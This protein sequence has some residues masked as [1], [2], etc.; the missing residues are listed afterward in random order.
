MDLTNV[1]TLAQ[2]AKAHELDADTLRRWIRKNEPEWAVKWDKSWVI[3]T[4]T[5]P[6]KLA[7]KGTRTTRTDN[8]HRYIAFLTNA[9]RDALIVTL[10]DADLVICTRERARNRRAARKL[11]EST[12]NT[13]T[14]GDD[15]DA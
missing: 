1:C 6:P 5:E 9:E 14:D 12:A 15:M 7:E 2:Y 13:E 11:A 8:R 3:V 4:S 10:G